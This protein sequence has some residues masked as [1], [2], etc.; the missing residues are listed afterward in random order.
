MLCRKCRREEVG[1][2]SIQS[3]LELCNECYKDFIRKHYQLFV[4]KHLM[5]RFVACLEIGY[6]HVLNHVNFCNEIHSEETEV[7]EFIEH[8]SN[9]YLR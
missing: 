7:L 4:P 6:T 5:S 9:Q 8:L 3:E 2:D 1:T